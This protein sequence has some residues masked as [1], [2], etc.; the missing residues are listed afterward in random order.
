MIVPLE[1]WLYFYPIENSLLLALCIVMSL[2]FWYYD[3]KMLLYGLCQNVPFYFN[4]KFCTFYA[5]YTYIYIMV[6]LIFLGKIY[7]L[8]TRDTEVYLEQRFHCW[9]LRYKI[10]NVGHSISVM[11]CVR[12][13]VEYCSFRVMA[14]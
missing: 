7:W 11:S 2:I 12:G 4:K 10:I 3:S 5:I 8:R 14:Y 1:L 13:H 6:N 9:S